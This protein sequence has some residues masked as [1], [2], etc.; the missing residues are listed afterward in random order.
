MT[1][2]RHPARTIAPLLTALLLAVPSVWA[3]EGTV[4]IQ[5]F[6]FS[7]PV[8]GEDGR[9][10]TA[11]IA[12]FLDIRQ[13]DDANTVCQREPRIRDAVN[14]VLFAHP[15]RMVN[16]QLDLTT[17][18]GLLHEAITA[19]IE[20]DVVIAVHVAQGARPAKEV[21]GENT[22]LG[23]RLGKS[24]KIGKGGKG[25][26]GGTGGASGASGASGGKPVGDVFK[27]YR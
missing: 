13:E 27:K 22:L 26:T 6:P 11:S 7:V 15:I 19:A 25:G 3:G 9:T 24:S 14:Q 18:D 2:L 8:V 1:V 17:V 5:M 12:T 16:R 21:V 23:C 4:S 10:V 20:S